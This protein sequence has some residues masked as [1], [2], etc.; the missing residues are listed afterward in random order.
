MVKRKSKQAAK[1]FDKASQFLCAIFSILHFNG[2]YLV[3]AVALK[4]GI[5]GHAAR[6]KKPVIGPDS[7]LIGELI[8]D[9]TL[10]ISYQGGS[11]GFAESLVSDLERRTG[12]R[13]V[14][15]SLRLNY[16]D[17]NSPESYSRA[18]LET[19]AGIDCDESTR[20]V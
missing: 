6:V 8:R 18:V 10:G 3:P 7:G 1:P 9:Y 11:D 17:R 14:S 4:S 15:D 16:L 2:Y 5:L 12:D 13:A 19:F 20:T